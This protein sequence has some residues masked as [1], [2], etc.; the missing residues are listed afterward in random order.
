MT[1]K[2]AYTSAQVS[3]KI[4]LADSGDAKLDKPVHSV[5]FNLTFQP[6]TILTAIEC[7]RCYWQQV[8]ALAA[9]MLAL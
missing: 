6:E 1:L 5:S 8:F 4:Y 2:V 7:Y 9:R 3:F